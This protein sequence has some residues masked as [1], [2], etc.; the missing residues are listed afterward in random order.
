MDYSKVSDEVVLEHMR[1]CHA[2]NQR[3]W[4]EQAPDEVYLGNTSPEFFKQAMATPNSQWAKWGARL[5]FP[6]VDYK[7]DVLPDTGSVLV[8]RAS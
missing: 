3:R 6:A 5:A 1:L 8:K 4:A 2:N 7:G